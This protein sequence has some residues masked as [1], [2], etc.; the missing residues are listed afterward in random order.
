MNTSDLT[1]THTRERI[2]ECTAKSPETT[3]STETQREKPLV[4]FLEVE[5]TNS[6][7]TRRRICVEAADA[8]RPVEVGVLGT[9]RTRAIDLG[10]ESAGHMWSECRR[11][12]FEAYWI[13]MA[14][15]RHWKIHSH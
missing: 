5:A 13:R 9:Y 2:P 4:S 3:K 14:W 1:N 8:N 10:R 11:A 6:H 7:S 15:A 12:S